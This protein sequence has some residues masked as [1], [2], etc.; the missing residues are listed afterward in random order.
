[1]YRKLTIAVLLALLPTMALAL[2]K[3]QVRK[4]WHTPFDLYLSAAEAYEMKTTRPDKVLFLDVRT[5]QEVHYIGIADQIDAHIP[6]QLDSTEWRTRR[7]GIRGTFR[8][9]RN[10]DFERA[11]QN[12]LGARGLDRDSPVIIM[13]TSGSRAPKAARALHKAGFTQVY[14]QVEGF[15]GIKATEGP[16]KGK[17][18]VAGWKHEGL[19]WSYELIKAKM[20]FNFD[21]RVIDEAKAAGKPARQ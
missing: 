12:A 20:Y 10:P 2:D 11:V 6:Y 9:P 13:C 5:H 18:L 14:T 7:D 15:E 8:K 17:R 4:K 3:S 21:P 19:P 1:M 16:L